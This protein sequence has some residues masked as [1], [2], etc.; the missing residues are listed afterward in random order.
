MRRL[1]TVEKKIVEAATATTIYIVRA[2]VW[3]LGNGP[4]YYNHFMI[5]LCFHYVVVVFF[6]SLFQR[7]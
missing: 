5:I 1:K 4:Q 2:C 3:M 6:S 7:K